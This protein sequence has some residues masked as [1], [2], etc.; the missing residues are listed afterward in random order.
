[1]AWNKERQCYDVE[2]IDPDRGFTD[3]PNAPQANAAAS[4][5]QYDASMK[6]ARAEID[7]YY[8]RRRY[9]VAVGNYSNG[10]QVVSVMDSEG[11]SLSLTADDAEAMAAELTEAAAIVRAGKGKEASRVWQIGGRS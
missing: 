10:R 3:P 8:K 1:M 5:G 4:E 11:R 9:K 2:T 7:E 6:A